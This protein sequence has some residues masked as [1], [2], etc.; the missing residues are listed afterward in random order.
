MR[1]KYLRPRAWKSKH[2]HAKTVL[3]LQER[4]RGITKFTTLENFNFIKNIKHFV[5]HMYLFSTVILIVIILVTIK[6]L[7]SSLTVLYISFHCISFRL[8]SSVF[9]LIVNLDRL[10][11]KLSKE[12]I[13]P[14]LKYS[15]LLF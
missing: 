6:L 2:K 5:N 1:S 9:K 10:G 7:S 13:Q 4:K 14:V 15:K 12:E 11:K 8:L 3:A